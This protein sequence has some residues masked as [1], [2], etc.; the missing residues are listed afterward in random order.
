MRTARTCWSQSQSPRTL[1]PHYNVQQLRHSLPSLADLPCAEMPNPS[2]DAPHPALGW[3][4]PAVRG[5]VR[6]LLTVGG[7]L[8]VRLQAAQ[9][10]HLPLSSIGADWVIDACDALYARQLRDAGHLLWAVDPMQPKLGGR[11]RDVAE[12]L[13]LHE[14]QERVELGWPGVYYC[15][16]LERSATW[17]CALCAVLEA[18]TLGELEGA[19]LLDDQAGCG[20]AFRVL[21]GLAQSWVED[22][23]RRHNM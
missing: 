2:G 8:S 18:A 7:W 22:A 4:V 19:V 13:V 23:T 6:R 12:G 5:A 16:C 1:P 11:P 15:V 17:R 20:P 3:Q 14:G 9:Y 10:A 21:K